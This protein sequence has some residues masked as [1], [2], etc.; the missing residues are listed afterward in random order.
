M[1]CIGFVRSSVE[2]MMY[3]ER[4]KWIPQG[5]P[6]SSKQSK[7]KRLSSGGTRHERSSIYAPIG[8][9]EGRFNLV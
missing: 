5:A 8:G 6:S 9:A 2:R 1:W 7:A 4:F 3:F